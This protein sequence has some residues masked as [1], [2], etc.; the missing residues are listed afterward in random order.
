MSWTP[1]YDRIAELVKTG[2]LEKV[3]ADPRVANRLVEDARRHLDSAAAA[4]AIEDLAG[5]YQLAYDVSSTRTQT[6]EGLPSTTW[7]TRSESPAKLER[8]R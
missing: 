2:E 5:A 1:G 6:P 7:K 4:A 8:P 3:S